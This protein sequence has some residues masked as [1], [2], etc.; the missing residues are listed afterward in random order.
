[1]LKSLPH[2]RAVAWRAAVVALYLVVHFA[3]LVPYAAEVFSSAGVLPDAGLS[4]LMR[5][6]PNILAIHDG[7]V[8][9]TLF[10]LAGGL[11]A[12]ALLHERWRPVAAIGCLYVLACLFG[13]NPLIRNP[14]LP[15]VGLSLLALAS[16]RRGRIPRDVVTV[17]WILLSVGYA[18]SGLVKLPAPSWLD[19]TA[20]DHVLQNPL[21]YE[22]ARLLLALPDWT[23]RLATWGTLGLEILFP[24]L[25]LSRRARPWA[26][27]AMTSLHLG[28]LCLI[29]FADL[30]LGMLVIHAVVFDERWLSRTADGPRQRQ[31]R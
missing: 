10:A 26:W 8:F 4:P 22:H 30:T 15:Y 25:A 6:F 19:G 9:V 23:R 28:L 3:A 5:A 20:F 16:A 13:R 11:A 21:A 31:E 18:Y 2:P 24:L 12:L 1:M 17:L 29:D 7:P 14:S 27:L